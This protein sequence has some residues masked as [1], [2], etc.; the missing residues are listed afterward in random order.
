M[1]I[2]IESIFRA[3][4]HSTWSFLVT[5][6]QGCYIPAYQRPYSWS[7]E[8][9]DRLFEDAIHGLDQL[10]TRENTISFLGTIIAIHDTRYQTVQ[11]LLQ[12]EMPPRVMT[13][14]DGQQR[15]S[16]IAMVNIAVHGLGSGL[17]KTV[18]RRE[19]DGKYQ[20]LLQELDTL[21][22]NARLSV[23]LDMLTGDD[24]NRFYPRIVRSIDDSWSRRPSQAK[25]NSPIAHLIWEYYLHSTNDPSASFRYRPTLGYGNRHASVERAFRHVQNSLRNITG[26]RSGELGFPDLLAMFQSPSF[27]QAI[28]GHGLPEDVVGLVRDHANDPDFDTFATA[29]RLVVL[30]KYFNDRMAFT[31]VNARNE[32]DAF[33][34]F[35][36]LNTTGQPLT[37]FETF[38]P[39]VIEAETLERYPTSPSYRYVA[40][41]EKY[42][43]A[44]TKAEAKQTATSDLLIPFAL[45]ETGR[46]LQKRHTDQRR[47]L[48]EQFSHHDLST[49]EEKRAFVQRLAHLSKFIRIAWSPRDNADPQFDIAGHPD[50]HTAT[51]FAM[52]REIRHDIVVAPLFRFFGD[53]LGG[54]EAS[55]Q[56]LA[57]VFYDGMRA[58]IAFSTLWRA[59]FGGTRGIDSCYREIMA[60]GI[61][62]S[63]IPPLA[64]RPEKGTGAV[65]LVHYKRALR[66][67]LERE[68][69]I[70]RE[71]WVNRASRTAIY[72]Q[73]TLT[74]YL[75]FLASHDANPDPSRPGMI[76]KGRPESEPLISLENWR[77]RDLTVE[78]VAPEVNPGS[79]DNE[80][81]EN[82]AVHSLGNLI[83]L[84]RAENSM[85]SNRPW[86]EKQAI[87]RLLS[88]RTSEEFDKRKAQC[89]EMNFSFS[90]KAEDV[91]A[92][93]SYSAMC[94]AVGL[95]SDEWNRSFVNE[96]SEGLA[97]LVWN[98]L[99]PWLDLE[100]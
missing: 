72:R 50:A 83:L 25:Y 79:W 5:N 99:A 56:T 65:S 10:I 40:E 94:R 66:S 34:M 35:E 64:V 22:A 95:K 67:Y 86:N 37:A 59:A 39:K 6:G 44:F 87:Y 90:E 63:A 26:K 36:A 69:I 14:I 60:S 33:D 74:R 27:T 47:Y 9:V 21:T 75:L 16:T 24:D 82:D 28:W 55:Q 15:L 61:A 11:P 97:Q 8:N 88:S 76:K 77:K 80:L 100:I 78:H 17:A 41:I 20:W 73:R 1:S 91:L 23:V 52:L 13:I 85:V 62:T 53:V 43:D 84:P 42:L 31:V 58:T 71:Q 46:K 2:D 49:I 93:S 92:R 68:R 96:R 51:G 7:N 3:T 70:D 19:S 30:A 81:Y 54:T 45:A 98:R 18:A 38:T 29:A 32:D 57:E 12:T 48:R 89:D 4:A